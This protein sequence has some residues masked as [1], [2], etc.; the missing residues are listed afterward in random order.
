[1]VELGQAQ[2]AATALG[3]GEAET[4][5]AVAQQV[6]QILVDDL[7]LQGNG[8][9]GDHQA[10][11][12]GLGAGDGGQAV[13]HGLAS[14]GPRLHRHH[15]GLAFAMA[16]VVAAD[17]AEDLR[18][19]GDHQALAVTRLEFLGLEKTGIG[20]LDLGLEFGAEH[21]VPGRRSGP[22]DTSGSWINFQ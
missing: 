18:H 16:F 4:Q 10:L 22:A 1:M 5:A 9:G 8:G 3:E 17:D 7:L 19:F 20:A 11:A 15:G 6:G 12:G 21:G 2:V 13:G 14:A